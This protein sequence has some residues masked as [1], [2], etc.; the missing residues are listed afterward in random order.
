MCKS[1]KPAVK[2]IGAVLE[3][4]MRVKTFVIFYERNSCIIRPADI[5]EMSDI[6]AVSIA[7]IVSQR[8][9]VKIGRAHV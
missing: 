3:Y 8:T 9:A 2:V 1:G 5:F 4:N 7:E 6:I